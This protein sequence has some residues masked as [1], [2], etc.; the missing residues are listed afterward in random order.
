MTHS[1]A[2]SFGDA[3]RENNLDNEITELREGE[4][5]WK[6]CF[7]CGILYTWYLVEYS[8]CERLIHVKRNTR[9]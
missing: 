9:N 5:E 1:V 6:E 4:R 7:L 2:E 3:G 8:D